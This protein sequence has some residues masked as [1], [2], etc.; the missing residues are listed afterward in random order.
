MRERRNQSRTVFPQTPISK[1]IAVKAAIAGLDMNR[2]GAPRSLSKDGCNEERFVKSVLTSSVCRDSIY[3]RRRRRL[4]LLPT[5]VVLLLPEHPLLLRRLLLQ[6]D[7]LHLLLVQILLPRLLLQ[8]NALHLLLV[9]ILL[10][11]L[12]LQADAVYLQPEVVLRWL[13][14]NAPLSTVLQF[15]ELEVMMR[16]HAL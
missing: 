2:C 14:P 10:P 16:R 7:A 5:A 8:A 4:W 9:Q 3:A 12:L 13:R 1:G 11:R 15:V 6:A